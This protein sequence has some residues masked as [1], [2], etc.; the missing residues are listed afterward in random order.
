M[1]RA[2]P[3][4]QPDPKVLKIE[5][6][7]RGVSVGEKRE[8]ILAAIGQ[9]AV[10]SEIRDHWQVYAR[11][12]RSNPQA[13]EALY[14][15]RYIELMASPNPDDAE[16]IALRAAMA[17]VLKRDGKYAPYQLG[18]DYL[19]LWEQAVSAEYFKDK[20]LMS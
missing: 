1:R 6:D 12:M 9:S 20:D 15:Q 17:Q 11:L 5:S 19:A 18:E 3:N 13:A 2:F 16:F 4:G 14:R 7:M 8:R 10:G